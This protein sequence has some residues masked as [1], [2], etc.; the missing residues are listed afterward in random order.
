MDKIIEF[1]INEEEMNQERIKEIEELCINKMPLNIE[2]VD[3]LL[4]NLSYLVRKKIADHEDTTIEDYSYSFKCDLAQSMIY[5]YLN[6]LNIKVNPR[7]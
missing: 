1:N 2:D 5:H 4:K 7:L 3:L 6:N